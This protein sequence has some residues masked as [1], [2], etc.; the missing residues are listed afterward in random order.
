MKVTILTGSAHKNGTTAALAAKFQQ[1]RSTPDTRYSGLT[2]HFT[3]CT[4]ASDATPAAAP[5][6]A[7]STPDDLTQ[8][9]LDRAYA[10]GKN[11]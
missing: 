2:R 5:G 7:F 6:P 10:L 3:T 8:T 4:S 11:L 1:G 9:D